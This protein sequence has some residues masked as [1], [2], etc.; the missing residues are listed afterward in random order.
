MLRNR[1]LYIAFIE[2]YYIIGVI[3][4]RNSENDIYIAGIQRL[5]ILMMLYDVAYYFLHKHKHTQTQIVNTVFVL[6]YVCFS[7]F[8]L[9]YHSL[10]LSVSHPFIYSNY[11]P[12]V[13]HILLYIYKV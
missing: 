13:H 1:T 12:I 11:Y 7:L 4:M 8:S 2:V 5:I 3:A 9:S 6:Y 10:C